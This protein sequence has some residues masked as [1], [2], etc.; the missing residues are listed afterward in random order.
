MS[1]MNNFHDTVLPLWCFSV[2][3]VFDSPSPCS[4]T[5]H[6]KKVARIFFRNSL[7]MFQRRNVLFVVNYSLIIL[8]TF[9]DH[10]NSHDFIH[11]NSNVPLHLAPDLPLLLL[12]NWFIPLIYCGAYLPLSYETLVYLSSAIEFLYLLV[13]D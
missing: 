12:S 6:G 4:F 13:Y 7:F 11:L 8:H 5:L 9:R 1:N 2:I 10:C 3:L